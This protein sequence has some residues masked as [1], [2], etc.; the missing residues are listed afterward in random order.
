MLHATQGIKHLGNQNLVQEVTIRDNQR[1]THKAV[2][3]E[4]NST[5]T[6]IDLN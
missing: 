1:K 6:Y 5:Y 2:V 3:N 4:N